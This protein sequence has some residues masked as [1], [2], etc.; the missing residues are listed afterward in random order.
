MMIV[1]VLHTPL[2]EGLALIL[3]LK[4]EFFTSSYRL[5]K[6]P[7]QAEEDV[8]RYCCAADR[9]SLDGADKTDKSESVFVRLS[10]PADWMHLFS[11]RVWLEKLVKLDSFV[12]TSRQELS[13]SSIGISLILSPSQRLIFS[14]VASARIRG[15][16]GML[17]DLGE[18]LACDGYETATRAFPGPTSDSRSVPASLSGA[19]GDSEIVMQ[20][21]YLLVELSFTLGRTSGLLC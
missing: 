19:A 1:N 17:R 8:N 7:T 21:T 12:W 9:F 14:I 18:I 15:D 2:L 11:T 13:P 6:D 3:V 4:C 10:P 5:G 20:S 16:L